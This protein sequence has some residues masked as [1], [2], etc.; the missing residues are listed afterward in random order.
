MA[1]TLRQPTN[2]DAAERLTVSQF[3][4]VAPDEGKFELIDG[5]M[6]MSPPP[7]DIHEKL[8]IFLLRL[9]SAYVE[10]RQLGEVR[11]SRTSVVLA[12]DLV[13]Q[14][15]L[16]FVARQRVDLIQPRGIFGAPDLVVE[17][18][19]AG[20]MRNDRS[21][22]FRA[23]EAA[24]VAE[25]WLIDPNGAKRTQFY[26]H[27]GQRFIH[28]APNSEGIFASTALPGFWLNVN[29]LWPQAQFVSVRTTLESILS[30]V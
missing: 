29:W 11:G 27:D 30:Q 9:I 5:V 22:K 8:Y 10:E 13:L 14:P 21:V 26:R 6:V 7:F 4:Q 12:D 18:L 28:V 20:T 16:L 24:G 2:V 23:Y 17:I 15:D 25:F 3:F 19:S 1:M